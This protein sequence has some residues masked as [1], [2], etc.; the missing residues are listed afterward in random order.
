MRVRFTPEARKVYLQAIESLARGRPEVA[1]AFQDRVDAGLRR[2][3]SFPLSGP[4]VPEF[5]DP[6]LR[7]VLVEPYRFFYRV[8]G[9]TVWIVAVWHGSQIPSPPQPD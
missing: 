1:R 6:A 9:K 5:P 8:H 7:E 4:T 3:R 2:L